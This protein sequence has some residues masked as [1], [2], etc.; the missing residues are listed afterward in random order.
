MKKV[1]SVKS[2][3]GCGTVNKTLNHQAWQDRVKSRSNPVIQVDKNEAVEALIDLT[4]ISA[5]RST[6]AL[7]AKKY[8]DKNPVLYSIYLTSRRFPLSEKQC[9]YAIG[10]ARRYKI[11]KY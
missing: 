4:D 2:G 7:L 6:A 3:H 8:K 9:R 10:L 1:Y 5:L 11:I